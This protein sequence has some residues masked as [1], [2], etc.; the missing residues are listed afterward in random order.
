V[1]AID[2]P[3]D[4]NDSFLIRFGYKLISGNFNLNSSVEADAD[5]EDIEMISLERGAGL[6]DKAI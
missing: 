4:Q 1:T 5:A 2:V 3:G 6:I